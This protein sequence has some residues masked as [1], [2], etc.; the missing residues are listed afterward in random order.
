MGEAEATGEG[1]I[2]I[3]RK[4]VE[5]HGGTTSACG[6]VG[7]SRGTQS[8][9]EDDLGRSSSWAT[10]SPEEED[11]GETDGRG[12]PSS[13]CADID[14]EQDANNPQ[15]MSVRKQRRR[16]ASNRFN[17][18]SLGRTTENKISVATESLFRLKMVERCL[19]HERDENLLA[20]ARSMA[21]EAF[22]LL[23]QARNTPLELEA[24]LM[25]LGFVYDRLR[26]VLST[27]TDVAEDLQPHTEGPF[28]LHLACPKRKMFVDWKR[29]WDLYPV[30]RR[31]E[32]EDYVRRKHFYL[33]REGWTV[34]TVN[35][36]LFEQAA[37]REGGRDNL[38]GEGT[39]D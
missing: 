30:H 14:G 9:S 37:S 34:K 26:A 20:S 12:P 19:R 15:T 36:V 33:A 16:N 8:Q 39:S 5:G 24:S 38:V 2:P 22:E 32:V 25:E 21:P 1:A 23:D 17:D 13:G 11:G 28:F 4:A 3:E 27:T 6:G 29:A 35:N 31:V 7:G 18:H 10:S